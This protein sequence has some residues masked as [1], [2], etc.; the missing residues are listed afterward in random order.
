MVLD[1]LAFVRRGDGRRS[2]RRP[3]PVR[4]S[5]G[6]SAAR[7][8]VGAEPAAAGGVDLPGA[9]SAP[10]TPR[11]RRD[12]AFLRP[13]ELTKTRFI[14][15]AEYAHPDSLVETAWL[16]DRLDDPSIR[17]IEVDEDTTAYE[18]GHIP[19]ALG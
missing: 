8:A 7:T 11:H 13:S 6:R 9:A 4:P 18:K 16:V 15:M 12:R 14:P 10:H 5:G 19:N 1:A 17:I 2:R 3:H